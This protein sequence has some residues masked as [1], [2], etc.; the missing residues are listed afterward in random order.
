MWFLS[1]GLL[2]NLNLC[3]H[4]VFHQLDHAAGGG[5]LR[6]GTGDPQGLVILQVVAVLGVELPGGHGVGAL[7]RQEV[8]LR[9]EAGAGG[10]AGHLP[11]VVEVVIV[12]HGADTEAEVAA[13]VDWAVVH[14]LVTRLGPLSWG[15]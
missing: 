8:F 13:G 7:G 14:T 12:R 4:F 15:M 10:G 6:L 2:K 3:Q 9:H 5:G 11:V 1:P